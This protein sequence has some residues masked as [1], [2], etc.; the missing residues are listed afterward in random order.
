MNG[1]NELIARWKHQRDITAYRQL[2]SRHKKMVFLYVNKYNG[3]P[4]PKEAREAEAWKYFD[5]AVQNYDP[6]SAAEFSTYLDYQLR[7]IDRFVKKHQ[8][9][10]RIP[11]ALAGKIGDYNRTSQQMAQ[12]LGRQPTHHEMS[13]AMDMDVKH[14][15]QL[16]KSLR[17]DLFEGKFESETDQN[18]EELDWLLVD[19][20]DELNE[21]E[22]RVYDHLIGY[23]VPQIS[24]KQELAIKLNISPGRLSQITG[25]IAK[26]IHPHLNKR[27]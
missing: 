2:K 26:K 14:I 23:K 12:Q 4:V 20:R 15:K 13:K 24:N 22:K 7:K 17:G 3:S 8:N 27:L 6:H 11:E 18:S 9:V 10:A 21:Q 5:D 16:H 1:D 25:S 19:L